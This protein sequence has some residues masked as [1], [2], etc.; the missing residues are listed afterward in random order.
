MTV[1]GL[2]LT[3]T[4]AAVPQPA[5]P[6]GVSMRSGRLLLI[7]PHNISVVAANV[8]NASEPCLSPDGKHV[9]FIKAVPGASIDTGAGPADPNQVWLLD[10]AALRTTRLVTSQD[11]PD[12][13]LILA[14]LSHPA[15]SADGR[16]VFFQSSAWAVSDSIHAVSLATHR[17]RFVCDGNSFS[18]LR[19]GRYRGMLLVEKHKYHS[20]EGGAY[21]AVWLVAPSGRELKRWDHKEL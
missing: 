17:V 15:F 8:T 2:L 9:A 14:G 4:L 12:V 7:Y 21:D 20:G 19:R 3:S 10:T 18:V 6:S 13:P 1:L 11:S 16:E 5:K